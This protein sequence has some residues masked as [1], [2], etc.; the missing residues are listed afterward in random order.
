MCIPI[1]SIGKDQSEDS[2]Q[3]IQVDKKFLK[4]N[5]DIKTY[6]SV[7][8]NL[9]WPYYIKG[10]DT[11]LLQKSLMDK[12][13]GFVG[14]SIDEVL[15][16]FFQQ[17][18]EE[19]EE[20]PY[21]DPYSQILITINID[22]AC[23]I[24]DKYIAFSIFNFGRGAA[25]SVR[26]ADIWHK[27]VNYDIRE[28][29]VLSLSDVLVD[30]VT[31]SDVLH[32]IRR[33]FVI[34]WSYVDSKDVL[35]NEFLL[36]DKGVDF[37]IESFPNEF[38]TATIN[39]SSQYISPYIK[40]LFQ[41]ET[42]YNDS[43]VS[44][45]VDL[46]QRVYQHYI[47]GDSS[48]NSIAKTVCTDRI[49][50][51][52]KEEFDYE[53]SDGDCYAIW[54]FR[55]NSQDGPNDSSMVKDIIYKGDGWFDVTYIDMGND[56]TTTFKL[57]EEYNRIMI[58]EIYLD[59]SF[60]PNKTV[61]DIHSDQETEEILSFFNEPAFLMTSD[62]VQNELIGMYYWQCESEDPQ[63]MNPNHNTLGFT[64]TLD[65]L[66]MTNEFVKTIHETS[67][68]SN[69]NGT[70]PA[71]ARYECGHWYRQYNSQ[72]NATM[73]YLVGHELNIEV[74]N[75]ADKNWIGNEIIHFEANP[76]AY[77][78]LMKDNNENWYYISKRGQYVFKKD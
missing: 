46:L 49:L 36:T 34:N 3:T 28:N 14:N 25:S 4:D 7:E 61:S 26:A 2:L 5:G 73:Y 11:K 17:Y 22:T 13:F 71:N 77:I 9:V 30:G 33:S 6:Y 55:T 65:G 44:N 23:Y 42:K 38:S 76:K 52:L 48:F 50:E 78:I 41:V 35:P 19:I 31:E 18:G 66:V 27:Y 69:I 8:L 47:F 51:R 62:E 53:C 74:M 43:L 37:M 16:T 56:G 57:V 15:S 39:M 60:F 59:E 32:E 54:H 1:D 75:F 72:N 63:Y 64:T 70:I 21:D 12:A 68:T 24:K 10:C 45:G 20:L 40:D 67:N 29:K 58:D